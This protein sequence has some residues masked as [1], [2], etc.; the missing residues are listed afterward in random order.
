MV[1]TVNMR[2]VI[3]KFQ[4]I[5]VTL[6]NYRDRA[7][8]DKLYNEYFKRKESILYESRHMIKPKGASK[9]ESRNCCV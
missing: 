3:A 9:D 6:N 2:M 5:Q 7:K 1:L 4:M 8:I